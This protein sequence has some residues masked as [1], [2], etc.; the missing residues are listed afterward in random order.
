L[1]TGVAYMVCSGEA[2]QIVTQ[3]AATNA[4][5]QLIVP[6]SSGAIIDY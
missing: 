6:V 1:S 2:D 4:T 5:L 3:S